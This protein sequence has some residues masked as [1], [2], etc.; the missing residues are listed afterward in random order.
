MAGLYRKL[1][2]AS[3]EE[4]YN[5]VDLYKIFPKN[6]LYDCSIICSCNK[7]TALRG[8]SPSRGGIYPPPQK[9][10]K[11]KETVAVIER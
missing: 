3:S 11:K 4:C 6:L 9:K 5:E 8:G 1:C 7:Q 2:F 10:K